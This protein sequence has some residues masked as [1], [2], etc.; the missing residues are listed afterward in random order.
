MSWRPTCGPGGFG[1]RC[2]G[3]AE[4][5]GLGDGLVGSPRWWDSGGGAAG[6]RE[7]L[8]DVGL[9]AR[10]QRVPSSAS[11]SARCGCLSPGLE[12]T[13]T[14]LLCCA[15]PLHTS[16]CISLSCLGF[17]R[18]SSEMLGG[19]DPA[20]PLGGLRACQ[21]FPWEGRCLVRQGGSSRETFSVALSCLVWNYY[22][23]FF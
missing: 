18:G 7:Q 21:G 20:Q 14:A 10:P 5:C 16:C 13:P 19:P 23:F 15:R 17:P 4:H 12:R 3:P 9:T 11:C 6:S 8:V 1:E 2:R 22:F